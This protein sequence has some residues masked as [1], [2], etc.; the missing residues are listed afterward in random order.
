MDIQQYTDSTIAE[1]K[2]YSDRKIYVRPKTATHP[3]ELDFQNAHCLVT[4]TSCAALDALQWGVPVITT[5][6]CSAK[7]LSGKIENIENLELP[8]REPLFWGLAW[9]QFT[10]DELAQGLWLTEDCACYGFGSP[11]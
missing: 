1:I 2:K 3:I 5:G 6:E 10:V 8:D 7:P 4:H 9:N 11:G